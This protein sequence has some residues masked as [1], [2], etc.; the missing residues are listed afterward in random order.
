LRLPRLGDELEFPLDESDYRRLGALLPSLDRPL[1][2]VHPGAS[3]TAR[4]WPAERFAAVA[5]QLGDAGFAIV[6]TGVSRER[7]VV[8]RMS[9][10]MRHDALDL[11]GLT[12]LG[13]LGALVSRA[14]LLLCNDTGISHIAAALQTPTVVISTGDNPA[15]W[16]PINRRL[17]RVLCHP[18]GVAPG[19]AFQAAMQLA[20]EFRFSS[21]Q[22][23]GRQ[24]SLM[25]L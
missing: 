6:L 16:A 19:D 11:C 21:P 15:R 7:I 22:R 1:A 20:N 25:A 10:N 12:D 2:V 5:D 3:V 8:E 17:H 14:Q 24:E 4:Q 23:A 13:A 18:G 9:R